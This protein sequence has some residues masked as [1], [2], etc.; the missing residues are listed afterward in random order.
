MLVMH[1]AVGATVGTM[2]RE[3]VLAVYRLVYSVYSRAFATAAVTAGI[4]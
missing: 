4:H 1:V 3:V 2:Y